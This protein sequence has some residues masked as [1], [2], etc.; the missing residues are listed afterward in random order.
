MS[1]GTRAAILTTVSLRHPAVVHLPRFRS[2]RLPAGPRR[3][4][5]GKISGTSPR[6]GLSATALRPPRSDRPGTPRASS[7][8]CT[9]E[10]RGHYR[11]TAGT[12]W[13]PH[14]PHGASALCGPL[15]DEDALADRQL[16]AEAELIG[17]I[18]TGD[19]FPR[20]EINSWPA[21]VAILPLR[22]AR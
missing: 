6:D 3:L 18:A 10:G 21:T 9:A 4:S 12:T 17:M 14:G 7:G 13:N 22:P 2:S 5:Y 16:L 15:P 11:P 19:I 8:C 1:T 20:M